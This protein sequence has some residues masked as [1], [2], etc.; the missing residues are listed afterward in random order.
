MKKFYAFLFYFLWYNSTI[1][2]YFT[3]VTWS[4]ALAGRD[5]VDLELAKE[6]LALHDTVSDVKIESFDIL[7][8]ISR[9]N[10]D[11]DK[12]VKSGIV[13]K[14]KGPIIKS[15]YQNKEVAYSELTATIA[16]KAIDLVKNHLRRLKY[17]KLRVHFAP[18]DV[19]NNFDDFFFEWM[20]K[21]FIDEFRDTLKSFESSKSLTKTPLYI[22]N[23]G[24]YD[25]NGKNIFSFE[26][27]TLRSLDYL[28]QASSRID[29]EGERIV[30]EV[31]KDKKVLE[32]IK[33]QFTKNFMNPQLG[34]SLFINIEDYLKNNSW[35]KGFSNIFDALSKKDRQDILVNSIKTFAEI[36]SSKFEQYQ[37]FF[38]DFDKILKYFKDPEA[39]YKLGS[40]LNAENQEVSRILIEFLTKPDMLDHTGAFPKLWSFSYYILEYLLKNPEYKFIHLHKSKIEESLL[41]EKIELLKNHITLSNKADELLPNLL[42]IKPREEKVIWEKLADVEMRKWYNDYWN[43]VENLRVNYKIQS[44]QLHDY[45]KDYYSFIYNFRERLDVSLTSVQ[46]GEWL[47]NKLVDNFWRNIEKEAQL[48]NFVSFKKIYS[49]ILSK[50]K[51]N[52]LKVK[53]KKRKRISLKS[54]RSQV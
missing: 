37:A 41:L 24:Y 29:G 54:G 52:K 16:T 47:N 4:K 38:S 43:K 31:L 6:T 51:N 32:I 12:K 13:Y 49:S 11:A 2:A 27:L 3:S 26:E 40:E 33:S 50:A 18:K 9:I 8:S 36:M 53:I 17:Q 15:E 1:E 34:K 48:T 46:L 10:S 44:N 21:S 23:F 14:P 19:P 28:L 30:Q 42:H 45:L 20:E 39:L 22:T 25:L 7:H 35:T 5:V